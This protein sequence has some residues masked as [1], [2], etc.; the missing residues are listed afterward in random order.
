MFTIQPTKLQS[1]LSQRSEQLSPNCHRSFFASW[2]DALWEI[3]KR[4]KIEHGVV[5]VPD[6]FCVDVINNMKEHGLESIF[7]RLDKNLQP[8]KA[9][10][11]EKLSKSKPAIVILFHAVGIQNTLLD[12]FNTWQGLLPTG[13]LLI[14]DSVHRVLSLKEVRILHPNHIIIDSLRKVVPLMGA[15]CITHESF[16]LKPAAPN[17]ATRK[18][19]RQLIWLW[20]QFQYY[21]Y[22]AAYSNSGARS[23]RW[24]VLAEKAMTAG[25][26]LIGDNYAGAAGPRIFS[27]LSKHVNVASI[28]SSKL[29]Q[30]AVYQKLLKSVL[31]NNSWLKLIPF[32][33]AAQLRGYPL[34]VDNSQ[35]Q[36]FITSLR[37]NGLL[38][39]YELLG[40]PWSDRQKIIYLPLGP[41]LSTSDID[42]VCEFLERAA[43]GF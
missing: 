14:E 4:K 20:L 26:D 40:C 1:Y 25:Y 3:L 29:W 30:V 42:A 7:Y 37:K 35:A 12:S 32:T 36:K 2:E 28:R 41:H 23:N 22:R 5:L 21:L 8:N 27:W 13:T 31:K 33:D 15:Q 18:Y 38:V 17:P 34:V 6:F 24:N 10:F 16:A 9:D 11:I 43:H 19:G 39:R